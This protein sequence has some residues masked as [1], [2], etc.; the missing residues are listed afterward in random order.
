MKD[1]A[2]FHVLEEARDKE[3][4]IKMAAYVKG[5]FSFLGV[6]KVKRK[7]IVKKFLSQEKNKRT[8]DWDFVKE[9]YEK[10]EREYQYI[11][12]DYLYEVRNLLVQKDIYII[13][14]L[15][16][17]KSSWDITD[18]INALIGYMYLRYPNIKKTILV[19]IDYNNIWLKRISIG[20]QV[21]NKEKTD[22][23]LLSRAILHNVYTKNFFIDKSIGVALREYSKVNNE[24]VKDFIE[25]HYLS[26][27]SKR[28]GSKY[29][30]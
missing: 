18:G 15:I 2:I 4:A 11:A 12:I 30:K 3:V 29:L 28:E 24:W 10:K 16:T 6:Q 8:I 19:W 7:K 9:C 5:E 27:L 25:N 17:T 21:G 14:K 26:G 20:F 1:Y 22:T 23:E 13:E